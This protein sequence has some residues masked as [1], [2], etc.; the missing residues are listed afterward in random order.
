MTLRMV[1]VALVLG[2]LLT[3]CGKHYWQPRDRG[4]GEFE[5]ESGQ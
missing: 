4:V 3:G 2:G 5:I 1:T